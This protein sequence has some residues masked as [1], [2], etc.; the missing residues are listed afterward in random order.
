[1]RLVGEGVQHGGLIA[2]D[3]L[4]G[5]DSSSVRAVSSR[6]VK[7]IL[8]DTLSRVRHDRD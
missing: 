8:E 3:T 1:M 2:H 6:S 7:K 5:E 4:C